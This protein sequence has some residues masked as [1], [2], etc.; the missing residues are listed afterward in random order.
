MN[1]GYT[2]SNICTSCISLLKG[3]N[4]KCVKLYF[5]VHNVQ[6]TTNKMQKERGIFIISKRRQSR[7]WHSVRAGEGEL[8]VEYRWSDAVNKNTEILGQK[9]VRWPQ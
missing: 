7:K 8:M 2:E 4:E 6:V 9:P 5:Y 3:S 1:N